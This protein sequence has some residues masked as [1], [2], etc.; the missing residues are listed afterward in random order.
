MNVQTEETRRGIQF[1]QMDDPSIPEIKRID[2]G[3]SRK[4]N[5]KEKPGKQPIS[6]KKKK[7]TDNAKLK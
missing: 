1:T 7:G 5:Q 3:H 4:R 2:K 6:Q